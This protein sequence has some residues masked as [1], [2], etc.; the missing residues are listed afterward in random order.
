[1]VSGRHLA[2][3]QTKQ[4]NT[5]RSVCEYM[6]HLPWIQ[7]LHNTSQVLAKLVMSSGT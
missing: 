4:V 2:T 5:S 3:L 7:D 6:L 1:M